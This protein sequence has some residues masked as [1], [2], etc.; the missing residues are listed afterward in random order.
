[1]KVIIHDPSDEELYKLKVDIT[2]GVAVMDMLPTNVQ[3]DESII[4]EEVR[5]LP[6]VPLERQEAMPPQGFRLKVQPLIDSQWRARWGDGSAARVEAVM[7]HARTFFKHSSLGTKY[8]LD[9]Q[10]VN[11]GLDDIRLTAKSEDLR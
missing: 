7:E 5:D 3:F 10:P 2:T 8:E 4:P 6:M 1:M 11:T 9:V